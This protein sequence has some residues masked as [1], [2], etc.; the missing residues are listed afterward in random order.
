MVEKALIVKHDAFGFDAEDLLQTLNALDVENLDGGLQLCQ[1]AG[2]VYGSGFE[3]QP[4]LLQKVA[5]LIP[6]VG[7]APATLAS[8]K[9][10]NVFFAV[11]Q[12]LNIQHPETFEQLPADVDLDLYVSKLSGGSGGVHIKPAASTPGRALAHHYFQR[13]LA[14][15][16]VS[17]LFIANGTDVEVV[18]FNE[19]WICAS[20]QLPFRYGGA[21]SHAVL[22]AKVQQ[23]LLD[24]ARQLTLAFGLL[25]LN[26]LDAIVH[27]TG[28]GVE[29]VYVL[30]INPRLSATIDLYDNGGV[31][32]ER[33]VQA[34]MHRRLAG[35][36]AWQHEYKTVSK[37][38]AIVYADIDVTLNTEMVWPDWV[39]DTPVQLDAPLKIVAG[40]PVCSVLAYA[41]SA[42]AAKKEV[43]TRVQ[44]I[45]N[46]LQST[47]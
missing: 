22:S 32:F 38:H 15:M 20:A 36:Y 29:Q 40:A 25:G 35:V 10:M 41:D 2:V 7:N 18:G 31:L 9:D 27:Q 17:L 6:V 12:K 47:H 23:Q 33:H 14:G 46:L 11:M 3:A 21:V 16:P 44:Q 19:Q 43:L 42:D 28:T 5:A 24:A 45:K 26:S 8:A 4:D 39:T 30:E 34:C 37:A 13:K 1:F